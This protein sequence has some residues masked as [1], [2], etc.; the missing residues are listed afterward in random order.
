MTVMLRLSIVFS[1]CGVLGS[2]RGREPS[3][4]S[5]P[6][7]NVDEL[8]RAAQRGDPRALD[9]LVRELA[10]PLGRICA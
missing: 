6:L 8:V 1:L 10:P 7:E 4:R 3:K 2:P 9:A 5:A